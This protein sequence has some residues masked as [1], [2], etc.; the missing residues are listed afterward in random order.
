MLVIFA[1]T[2]IGL[3]VVS[4][5]EISQFS[6]EESA[7]E[8]GRF[9]AKLLAE[10]GVAIAQHPNVE[11][12]D[13]VLRQE[14]PDGRR[15]NVRIS[16]EGRAILVTLLEE[17]LFIDTTR[18]LFVLWGLDASDAAIA[19][20]SLADWVD[21]NRDPRT[22]GAESE[23]Y[24]TLDYPDFPPNEPFTNI[25]QM[26]LVRGMDKVARVQPRWRDYFTLYGDGA[27]DIN[28]A[29]ADLIEAFFGC[30]PDAAVGLIAT[31]NGEDLVENTEDDYRFQST[32]EARV[33]L[34]M[35]DDEW[36]RVSD[37]VTFENITKRIESI[38]TVGDAYVYRLIVLTEND[39]T[40][41]DSPVARIAQ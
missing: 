12:G 2:F 16:S 33:L 22:N 23:Y 21:S 1:V 24:A 11:P 26:L 5:M 3:I 14:F 15:I 41:G 37:S 7:L 30:T 29:P 28:T 34:G 9:Q 40:S 6:W 36:S 17:D 38:G 25:E 35:S 18:E 20:D 31:R 27:I 8:R 19:A 32:D 13:P 10:S 39:G 4:L